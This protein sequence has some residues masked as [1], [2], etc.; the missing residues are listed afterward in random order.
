MKEEIRGKGTRDTQRELIKLWE[1]K[2]LEEET[3]SLQRWE[4]NL[5]WFEQ[6]A[7][8]FKTQHKE[9]NP[10][11]KTYAEVVKQKGNTPKDN[12]RLRLRR[13]F[14]QKQPYRNN[15]RE[16]SVSRQGYQG[17]PNQSILRNSSQNR[18][19]RPQ[20]QQYK[21]QAAN[22]WRFGNNRYV[23][24]Q[25]NNRN[26]RNQGNRPMDNTNQCRNFNQDPF[27][28]KIAGDQRTDRT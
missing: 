14:T 27:F 25:Y 24:K 7:L 12:A 10:L 20:L 4:K 5:H 9:Q 1:E 18:N 11:M 26:L 17:G 6:Y 23:T 22:Q 19:Q 3:K 13:T 8:N 28:G 15:Q 16:Q 2:C 21:N